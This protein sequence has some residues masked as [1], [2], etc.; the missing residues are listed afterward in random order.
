VSF[1][2]LRKWGRLSP[3]A[4]APVVTSQ[5]YVHSKVLIADDTAAIIGSANIND[6]SLFGDRD[7]EIAAVVHHGEPMAAR[8]RG[9]EAVVSRFVHELRMRLWAEHLGIGAR[10]DEL[11][12]IADPMSAACFD[13]WNR[14]TSQNTHAFRDVFGNSIPDNSLRTLSQ[15]GPPSWTQREGLDPAAAA[16]VL[17]SKVIGNVVW[18]PLRFLEEDDLTPSPLSS[19]SVLED[20]VFQ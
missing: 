5:I 8:M 4:S 15:L 10:E 14:R 7:S 16:A 12:A 17:S 18:F 3:L 9:E 11:C 2:S 19:E 13:L 6:R 20:R 1:R